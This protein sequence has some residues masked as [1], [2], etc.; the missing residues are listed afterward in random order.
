MSGFDI[1]PE[2]MTGVAKDIQKR[3]GEWDMAVKEIYSK[4]AVL[5]SQFEGEAN[6]RI[7]EA[8]AADKPKYEALS[9]LMSEYAGVIIKAAKAYE[10]ADKQAADAI[11]KA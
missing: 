5:D 8:M 11:R 6:K 10:E 3:I 2:M 9:A 1:S 7:N 4:Y